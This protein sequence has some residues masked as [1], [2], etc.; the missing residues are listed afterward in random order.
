MQLPWAMGLL[1]S[2][3]GYAGP[4]FILA[5]LLLTG[6]AAAMGFN[7]NPVKDN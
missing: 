2:W 5:G 7:G 6:I 4:S 3:V 1:G